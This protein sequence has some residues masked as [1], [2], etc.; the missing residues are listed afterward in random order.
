M[1][2]KMNSELPL[3]SII[4]PIYNVENYLE[5]CLQSIQDQT[6]RN[7]E[8]LLINDGSTD[9]SQNVCQ[10]FIESDIRFKLFNKANEGIAKTRN[11][12]LDQVS[13]ESQYIAF[14]DSDDWIE[15]TYL[16]EL[17]EQLQKNSSDICIF[18]EY[19]FI[20]NRGVFRYY[21]ADDSYFVKNYEKYQIFE[22]LYVEAD[23]LLVNFATFWGSLFKTELFD[24]IRCPTNRASEDAITLY[25]LYMLANKITYVNKALYCY[26]RTDSG[27][28]SSAYQNEQWLFDWL[29]VQEE[30]ISMLAAAGIPIETHIEH[31]HKSITFIEYN[32]SIYKMQDTEAYRQIKEKLTLLNRLNSTSD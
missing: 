8:V 22:D 9:L 31:Y 30:R 15:E 20:E 7:I 14:V 25:K 2:I 5:R 26:R 28:T 27:I 19:D 16:E 32:A 23:N 10:Q 6:Y 3:I 17:Y 4:V 13:S 24:F 18:G 11:F 12:G 21:I 29:G 1:R